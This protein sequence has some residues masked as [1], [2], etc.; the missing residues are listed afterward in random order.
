MIQKRKRIS[1]IIMTFILVAVL[2]M[3]AAVCTT[4]YAAT[5]DDYEAGTTMESSYK[6]FSNSLKGTYKNLSKVKD[7]AGKIERQYRKYKNS[8]DYM[9]L[10]S[11]GFIWPCDAKTITSYFGGRNSPTAGASSNHRGI[12]IGASEGSKVYASAA[13]TVY[14]VSYSSHRGNYVTIKHNNNMYTRYQ[15]LQKALVST[16][17]KVQ[18]GQVIAKSGHTGIG[19]GAHLHFE[20]HKGEPEYCVTE[21]DPLD[22]VSP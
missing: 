8:D 17:D 15:H 21:V 3:D 11:K 22:Y 5:S 1:A 6:T 7:K 14:E 13:G 20:V 18:Q 2:C 10:V 19:T 9:E 16:G 12:D 4:A